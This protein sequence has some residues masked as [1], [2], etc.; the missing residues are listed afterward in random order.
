ML[1]GKLLHD[2]Y[3][4]KKQHLNSTYNAS[5][6]DPTYYDITNLQI[7]VKSHSFVSVSSCLALSPDWFIQTPEKLLFEQLNGHTTI[8]D[9]TFSRT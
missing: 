2:L 3:I 1:I 9:I 4:A 7:V 6:A 5:A 8:G